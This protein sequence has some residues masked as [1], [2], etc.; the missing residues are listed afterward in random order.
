[1]N[2][3]LFLKQ[4]EALVSDENDYYISKLAN[5]SAA[6]NEY[7]DRLNWVGFYLIK[8]DEEIK[9][10]IELLEKKSSVEILIEF[11]SF[12]VKRIFISLSF[13]FSNFIYKPPNIFRS[14]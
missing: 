14:I 2:N 8:N 6:I 5:V 3:E 11:I 1:M 10:E 9:C 12:C 4:I 13:N 7:L